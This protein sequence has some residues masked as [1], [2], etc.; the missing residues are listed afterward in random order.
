MAL[1]LRCGRGGRRAA[2]GAGAVPGEPAAL[3]W[4]VCGR[5]SHPGR[6]CAA[7]SPASLPSSSPPA[8]SW[9]WRRGR[10]AP[11]RLR[12]IDDVGSGEPERDRAR[13]ARPA[14]VHL[15]GRRQRCWPPSRTRRTAS[16]SRSTR[17]PPHVVDAILAVE[18]AG[19]WIHDGY[20]I[21]GMLAGLHGQ[22]RLRRHQ[23]GRLDHHP[24]AGE[25]RPARATEQ[26]LDRKVQEV[27][28]AHRLEKQ[29]T[30]E[31]IL[32]RY[33]NT[34]YFGNHAYGVQ[35]AAETYFGVGGR[36]SSTWARRRMLAG[37]IRNPITLQ[38]GP[39][40]RAGG[41]APATSPSTAWSTS[42]WLTEDEATCRG[43]RRRPTPQL[44]QVLPAAND[45][46]PT[47][48]EQQLLNDPRSRCWA[49]PR[50]ERH[51]RV[52]QG[53]LRVHTTFDPAA[54]AAGA[55]P[56]AT[57]ELPLENGVFP[58]PGVNP[59]DG[60]AQP[61]DRPRSCR[62]SP[63]P[64]RCARWSAGPGS[65]A[66]S[67]TS[68]PRTRGSVGSSFKT[69]V[70]ATI[71]EQG[72]SPDDIINGIAPVQL[73]R[74][75]RARAASTRSATT[76]TAAA[77]SAPSPRP[78]SPRRTARSCASA[79]SPASPERRRDGPPA[80]H[81][82]QRPAPRVRSPSRWRCRSRRC[83]SAS[84]TSPRSRW[85]RPTPPSPTT[86]STT[87]R[88][89]IERIED[90]NGNVIYAAHAH[91]RAAHRPRDRPAGHEHPRAE[92]AERHRHPGP[93][94]GP[95]G[96]R[97]DGHHPELHRR[98]VRRLHAGAVDGGVAGWAGP[99]VSRS[100]LGG[101]GITGGSYPARIWGAFMNA[102]QQGRPDGR[103]PGTARPPR[104]PD[105]RRCP[106]GVDLTPPPAPPPPTP[107]TGHAARP[108]AARD[109]TRPPRRRS[110]RQP[111]DDRPGRRRTGRRRRHG[112]RRRRRSAH[113][114]M[115]GVCRR[116]NADRVA[117]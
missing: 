13:P 9:R 81:P 49:R 54:Q 80:G 86:A 100:D 14:V 48:V 24:A 28:L 19:F 5:L 110:R 88:T 98:L 89:S 96:R 39:L 7:S 75:E 82:D 90:R 114:P 43:T 35:A 85:R 115:T 97:Q 62:S 50:T 20:N 58:Q 77:A 95:A 33:L 45:Y 30:K 101:P 46:F 103:L 32:D 102:W 91:A 4:V 40:P 109:P 72:Y 38:P 2:A 56:P 27:V 116:T 1:T 53:G 83:R 117:A 37:I 70:L 51:E 10:A 111:A 63:P 21:R 61:G 11:S 52:F 6:R 57:A 113:R 105:A 47:E 66:T 55:W 112:G 44:H 15:R 94:L 87:R 26:T 3:G 17:C 74:R 23:P 18:D 67:T 16:R 108:T 41:R 22:R 92:R 78:P 65:T 31:E 104:R 76:P 107:R 106:G 84:P 42:A 36:S 69:F 60:R 99:R 8:S 79:S 12:M 25:A 59:S 93:H 34:V 29:M 73:R 68:P 71:M 64:A